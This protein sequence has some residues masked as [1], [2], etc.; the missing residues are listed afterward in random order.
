VAV[1]FFGEGAVNQGAFHE[2]VNLA[3]IWNL[4]VLFVCENNLYA[5]FTDSRSMTRVPSVARRAEAGYGVAAATVDGNDVEAVHAAARDAVERC[6]RGDGPVLLEAETYRWHGHYEGDGQPYKP[7]DEAEGWRERDPLLVA[8]ARLVQRGD[9]TQDELDGV[10]ERA[11]SRIDEAVA[12]AR[13]AQAPTLE[14]AY[15]HVHGD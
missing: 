14:E 6:R 11:R 10:Q 3:A 15:A 5:E 7:G 12:T 13:A 2:A 9:A 1:S 4:P 8:G